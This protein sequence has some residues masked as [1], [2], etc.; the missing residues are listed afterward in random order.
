MVEI[1][2]RARLEIS[3]VIQYVIDGIAGNKVNKVILYGAKSISE[4]KRKFDVYEVM[5]NKL[6]HS[7]TDDRKKNR[8]V[9][10]R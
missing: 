1:A 9:Q 10:N 3:A 4:L 8:A 5:K 7:K 2:S 6:K